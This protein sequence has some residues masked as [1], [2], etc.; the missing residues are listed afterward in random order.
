VRPGV[1]RALGR[2]Q[3]LSREVKV[4]I[5]RAVPRRSTS[6]HRDSGGVV[7]VGSSRSGVISPS[8]AGRE[9]TGRTALSP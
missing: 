3:Y 9:S 2:V 1:S 8:P 6:L 7:V 4:R 5:H